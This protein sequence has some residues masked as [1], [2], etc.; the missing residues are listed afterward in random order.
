MD[1]LIQ[2]KLFFTYNTIVHNLQALEKKVKCMAY[3]GI[4]STLLINGATA[5]SKFQIPIY[6]LPN[7]VCNVN[8][9]IGRARMLMETTLCIWDEVSMIPANAL[10]AVN[11]RLRDITQVNKPFGGKFSSV[12]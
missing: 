8:C 11:L 10:Q 9:Q 1:Q 12:F 2:V 7:S 3:S 5:Q 4:T 6:L